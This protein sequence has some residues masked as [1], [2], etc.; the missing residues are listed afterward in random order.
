MPRMGLLSKEGWIGSFPVKE[1]VIFDFDG[2]LADT[3][4]AAR[5][6]FNEIAPDYGLDEVAADKVADL[7]HF[8]LRELLKALGMKQRHVPGILRRGRMLMRERLASLKPCGDI[9]DHLDEIRK[10]TERCG[11][12]TSNSVENV[13]IFLRKHGARH[14]FDFISTC[15][16]L[17]GK[18][19]Y[20]RA[21]AKTY[22]IEPSE[23]V[24]IGDEVRD[25]KAGLKAGV[26]V[27]GV[28]W[29]FNSKEA[30]GKVGPSALAHAPHELLYIL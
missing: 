20:L 10:Q 28:T 23:M 22:S 13:E 16:K 17:K 26:S 3:L 30:L 25:M 19:K 11:I 2:T 1:A 5:L 7:R 18:A 6:I 29:G 24:Y 12:L 8:N 21:V 4:E 9:F 14:H 27:V 15:S